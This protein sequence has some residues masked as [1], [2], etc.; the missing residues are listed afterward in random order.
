MLSVPMVVAV[1]GGI[2]FL[3]GLLGGGIEVKEVRLP[4]M[5]GWARLLSSVTG[6]MLIGIAV[7]LSSPNT[8]LRTAPTT[9][10]VAADMRCVG[11]ES[12]A[13]IDGT[14]VPAP[15]GYQ[16]VLTPSA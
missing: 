5:P 7:W 3:V 4:Q 9:T 15:T 1:V 14:A 2:A 16:I 6:V 10:P 13:T 11:E 12:G 8:T